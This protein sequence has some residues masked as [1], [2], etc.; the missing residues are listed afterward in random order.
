MQWK[1]IF[2]TEISCQLTE[3]F[4]SDSPITSATSFHS[5][6]EKKIKIHIN[7]KHFSPLLFFTKIITLIRYYLPPVSSIITLWFNWIQTVFYTICKKGYNNK[8]SKQNHDACHFFKLP[9]RVEMRV[10]G[11]FYYIDCK[12]H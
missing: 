8:K 4:S 9:K 12:S 3:T 7:M 11:F 2:F 6:F 5:S 10:V 1:K